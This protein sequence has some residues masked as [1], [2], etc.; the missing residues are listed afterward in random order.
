MK[1]KIKNN[2]SRE[3]IDKQ[4]VDKLIQWYE[5]FNCY[6]G[7]SLCQDDDCIIEAPNILADILDEFFEYEDENE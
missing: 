2:L 5:D 7:E 6:D 1:L 3:Q 4:I